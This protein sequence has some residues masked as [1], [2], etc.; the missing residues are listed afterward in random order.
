MIS[1]E[2]YIEMYRT[3]QAI[4]A[5][6]ELLPT[7]WIEYKQKDGQT[8]GYH[9]YMDNGKRCYGDPNKFEETQKAIE[10]RNYLRT[11]RTALLEKMKSYRHALKEVGISASA[12]IRKYNKEQKRKQLQEV[13]EHQEQLRVPNKKYPSNYSLRTMRGEKVASKSEMMIADV[14]FRYGISYQYEKELPLSYNL[15]FLPDFTIF[16]NGQVYFWEH[17]GLMDDP[18]YRENWYKK[19][20]IYAENGI[21]ETINLIISSETRDR[22]LT[23]AQVER[24]V[25][26]YFNV[27][28][29]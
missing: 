20:A 23:E 7:G 1:E 21:I 26:T 16:H 12:I 22:P 11:Q 3:L 4:T 8:Y 27:K 9:R 5:E 10:R 24:L 29:P 6:I 15:I 17:L 2:K 19:R 14:L 18:N 28:P 13:Y 25:Q